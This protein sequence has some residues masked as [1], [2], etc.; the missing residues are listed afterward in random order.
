MRRNPF[1]HRETTSACFAIGLVALTSCAPDSGIASDPGAG[2]PSETG[3][4]VNGGGSTGTGGTVSTGGSPATGGTVNTRGYS[5]G[6][7]NAT[8]FDGSTSDGSPNG[9]S[10]GASGTGGTDGAST[11]P[12][13]VLLVDDFEDGD[14]KGWIADMNDGTN[15]GNW[16]VVTD[17]ASKVNSEQTEYSDPSFAVGG[18]VAWTDQVLEAKMKFVS[19]SSS[20]PIAYLAIRLTTKKT[21]YFLELHANDTNGSLKIRKRVDGSTIDLVGSFKTGV[22]VVVGTWYTIGLSAVGTTIG[23]SFNGT[24]IG[25]ATDAELTHG[26]IA[27]G[28][29]DAVAEFDDVKVTSR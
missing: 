4:A 12:P 27:L 19:S 7:S 21:Y 10:S 28:V 2:A 29:V 13:G 25:T 3:G 16:S 22:P 15:V 9:G 11:L 17:G 1:D 26:G 14:T 24:S 5:T 6:G 23:G 20:S 8:L 18:D